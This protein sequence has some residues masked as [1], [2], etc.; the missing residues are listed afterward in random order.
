LILAITSI[1]FAVYLIPGLW[2]AELKAVSAFVPPMGTQ[3]FIV[4]GNQTTAVDNTKVSNGAVSPPNKY[5]NDLKIYHPAAAIKNNLAIYHDY[6][7]AMAAAKLLKKPLL[8]D[9]TGIQCVNCRKFEGAIWPHPDVISRMKND[10]VLASLF[11]DYKGDLSDNEKK[12]S[13]LLKADIATVGDK[14]KDLQMQLIN[15]VAQPNYVFV[16]LDGKLLFPTGYGY[17]PSESVP[18]FVSHLDKVKA[19][20]QKRF[21]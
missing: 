17:E 4:G 19:E 9:F 16:D 18:A 14:Y 1:A 5:V 12:Y 8:L 21:P 20:F 7:E 6:D 2:G 11:T 10:F 3:D 13:E 15:T